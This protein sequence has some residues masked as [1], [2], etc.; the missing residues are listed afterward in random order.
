M[1]T[2]CVKKDAKLSITQVQSYKDILQPTQDEKLKL[3]YRHFG[4]FSRQIVKVGGRTNKHES[5]LLNQ[6]DLAGL[7]QESAG[8]RKR[9]RK[10][11]EKQ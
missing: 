2:D 11:K 4:M 7:F 6:D 1:T 5:V 10:T 3:S 9:G 8:P